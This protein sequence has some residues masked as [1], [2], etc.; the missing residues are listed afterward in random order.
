MPWLHHHL[1]GGALREG[2][3]GEN[4]I[5]S[6]LTRQIQHEKFY[7][8]LAH[9]HREVRI[10][11]AH[12][13][14]ISLCIALALVVSGHL[15]P[16]TEAEDTGSQLVEMLVNQP[17][18]FTTYDLAWNSAHTIAVAVGYEVVG[19]NS[20]YYYST[21]TGTWT[22]LTDYGS[23]IHYY[24]VDYD[25][26]TGKFIM[27][28]GDI[29]SGMADFT[30]WVYG[31]PWYH[32]TSIVPAGMFKDIAIFGSDK[33][34]AVAESGRAYYYYYTGTWNSVEIQGALPAPA[35]FHTIFYDNTNSVLYLGG[36]RSGNATAYAVYL[37]DL[38]NGWYYAYE[39]GPQEPDP[40]FY[41]G[42]WSSS[43][44]Y[45]LI[46]GPSRIIRVETT[47]YNNSWHEERPYT[48]PPPARQDGA[49]V[50]MGST[51]RLLL[52]GGVNNLGNY[53]SDTWEYNI[54]TRRWTQYTSVTSPSPRYKHAMAYDPNLDVVVLYGG[55]DGSGGRNDTWHYDPHTHIWT[56]KSAT[57]PMGTLYDHQMTYVDYFNQV[58]LY[59]GYQGGPT[60]YMARW[61]GTNWTT[62]TPTGTFP[63]YNH[64]MAYD[65]NAG[66]IVS[67][68]GSGNLGQEGSTH[69]YNP[70]VNMWTKMAPST[71]PPARTD[72]TMVWTYGYGKCM[73]FGGYGNGTYLSDLWYY[74]VSG[75]QW[76]SFGYGVPLGMHSMA[77]IYPATNGYL[78][79]YIIGG[80]DPSSWNE[81]TFKVSRYLD[82]KGS[83]LYS[84]NND[85]FN[86]VDWYPDGHEAIIVGNGGRIYRHTQG[87]GYCQPIENTLSSSNFYAV[88]C[89]AP[90]SP[91]YALVLGDPGG[92]VKVND[93]STGSGVT[94]GATVPHVVYIDV[95]NS[96]NSSVNNMQVNVDTGSFS[97][98]YY[99]QAEL[100]SNISAS[101]L[102]VV[103]LYAWRDNGTTG[104][105]LPA[106]LG[107]SFVAPGYENLRLHYRYNITTGTWSQLYPNTT[108]ESELRSG[109]CTYSIINAT[110]ATIRVSFLPKAQFWWAPGPFTE[111][112]GNRYNYTVNGQETL[113][114]LNDPFTW[115]I[116]VTVTDKNNT[117]GTA[118][119]E[120]GIYK[121]TY[122]GAS[123][124]PGDL[125]GSGAPGS[126]V[127]LSPK[128]NITFAANCNYSLSVYADNNL[129]GQKLGQVISATQIGVMG[130]DLQNWTSPGTQAHF[131]GTGSANALYLFGS[132]N[133][134]KAP[135]NNYTTTHTGLGSVGTVRWRC[136]IPAVSEDRYTTTITYL[137]QS[138][139]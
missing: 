21:S 29:I 135:R 131:N 4:Q 55:Y 2:D 124:L 86:D 85:T 5:D 3:E 54:F 43:A 81:R 105:D 87:A 134:S 12:R 24:G 111:L 96:T 98:Y 42:D 25:S 76:Y 15:S 133:G 92:G 79:F 8:S 10:M 20:S 130:G 106:V 84:N 41:D 72:H 128:G 68:G 7:L 45:G 26:S 30:T 136:I 17:P 64:A 113:S 120:F 115:D 38:Q 39:I 33:F 62:M 11:T 139:P 101:D 37:E 73:I 89:K 114:A 103:D 52:F 69:T 118:Y 117:Q 58:V 108:E 31:Q 50:Y 44:G 104:V 83:E 109:N 99:V 116:R 49:M 27:V 36:D 51:Q 47:P 57:S 14:W 91:G 77:S 18:N 60:T 137:I 1:H 138:K 19:G 90:T 127:Y 80:T 123:G 74:D 71:S 132:A 56:Q 66:V 125:S 59:G 23:N 121:W 40:P 126:T 67:F 95:M 53:T 46:V 70:S 97:N 6:D 102:E 119:E 88:A 65:P 16:R 61:N 28:G 34:V 93:I 22:A 100:Y 122:I 35:T 48:A 78:D 32:N 129:I 107:N 9:P 82:I 112:P 13:L 94:L 75:D 110:S 63:V